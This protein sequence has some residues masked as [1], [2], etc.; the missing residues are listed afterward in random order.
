MYSEEKRRWISGCNKEEGE[1]YCREAEETEDPEIMF[2]AADYLL[3]RSEK[4]GR[5]AEA[6]FLMEKAAQGKYTAAMLA[7][8][9]MY[10]YGWGVGKSR[11]Y[12]LR[13]YKEAAGAGSR[14]AEKA[15]ARLKRKR[16]RFIAAGVLILFTAAVLIFLSTTMF[17]PF[18]TGSGDGNPMEEEDPPITE[19][20]EVVVGESTDLVET[21]T[22]EE[23]QK[24]LRELTEQYDDELVVSGQRSTNRLLLRFEGAVLDLTDFLADRV[25]SR[26]DNM[27]I[28]Q[29]ASEEEAARCLEALK[30]SDQII[31]AEMDEYSIAAE[32]T[33]TEEGSGNADD[34]ETA[35]DM[36]TGKD[37]EAGSG[38]D[39]S[40]YS[41][42]TYQYYT[43]G[44]EDMGLDHLARWLAS[45][46]ET[47][48]A[49]VAVVDTGVKPVDGI[50]SRLLSG[51][52]V[53]M[54]GDG[55][56]D[57]MG[58]G[59][60]V[61]GTIL[62]CTQGLDVQVLPVGV[63]GTGQF[64]S[65]SAICTG[66]EYAISREADV[67][68]MSLGGP[69][70]SG[71]AWQADV[72]RRAVSEGIIVVASA[73]NGDENGIPIDT[74]GYM[75]AA[76]EECIVVGAVDSSHSIAPFSNYGE[77]VDVCAPGVDIVS[78]SINEQGLESMSG[79]SM[80]AP[81]ISAL[82]VMLRLYLP[83]AS[84]EQIEKYIKDYSIYLGDGQYYGE[85]IPSGLPF[86]EE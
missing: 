17:L 19:G 27:V 39:I 52:D 81:H 42:G 31:F 64:T 23:F 62:D 30:A 5:N 83:D 71:S 35:D 61:A 79:T 58:H 70:D 32:D 53:V 21:E 36:A 69:D 60:H 7:M 78:Y 41:G 10:E 65:K 80:A 13:W 9:Q 24:S 56:T 2:Q 44:C 66:L 43:W 33:E 75:P 48:S 6:V 20:G 67:I 57:M 82:A 45:L 3:A 22:L 84:P 50:R 12:A 49:V 72:I 68:N 25:V 28:I 38:A 14:E 74:A 1:Q 15:L 34:A 16:R 46:D 77:S 63:F 86:I 26:E 47:G 4:G 54:G 76:M 51:T 85:G 55:Q 40:A 11:K 37:V 59:T 18:M 8:G 29:F 73:G